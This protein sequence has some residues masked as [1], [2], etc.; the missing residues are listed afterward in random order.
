MA[1]TASP[2]AKAA[3]RGEAAHYTRYYPLEVAVTQNCLPYIAPKKYCLPYMSVWAYL[4]KKKEHEPLG[5]FMQV[6]MPPLST[7]LHTYGFLKKKFTYIRQQ[8]ES[9]ARL[10]RACARP[11]T[12][13]GN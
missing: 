2:W 7:L 12:Y 5:L 10:P 3:K 4:K 8:R 1:H 9:H 13:A 6:D 11:K